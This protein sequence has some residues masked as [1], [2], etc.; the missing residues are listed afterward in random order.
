MTEKGVFNLQGV[1]DAPVVHTLGVFDHVDAKWTDGIKFKGMSIKDYKAESIAVDDYTL[2]VEPVTGHTV[3]SHTTETIAIQLK[4][5]ELPF[6]GITK[7]LLVPY[8]T[9]ERTNKM[10]NGNFETRF[11]FSLFV[12]KFK[13]N[14]CFLFCC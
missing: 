4:G 14:A 10:F 1:Y 11:G 13:L 12:G 9:I 2:V 5:G 8:A 3:E 6:P 7:D